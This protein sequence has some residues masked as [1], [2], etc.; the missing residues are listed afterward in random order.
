MNPAQLIKARK[1]IGLSQAGLAAALDMSIRQ[2]SG[3][4]TG[5]RPI[6]KVV[7]LALQALA[8]NATGTHLHQPRKPVG[9]KR[10][11][12]KQ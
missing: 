8:H 12:G 4:E 9:A 2:I 5:A 10:E 11:K 7:E 6:S 1:I 3:M